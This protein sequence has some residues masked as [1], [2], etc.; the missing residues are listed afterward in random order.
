MTYPAY[1]K[2]KESG[3]PW[4]DIIPDCWGTTALKRYLSTPVTDGPHETPEF[5]DEGVP[6]IS[7]EAIKGSKIDFDKKRGYISKEYDAICAKKYKPKRG[8][9]Y[10]V[11]SGATTGNVAMV[12]TDDDFNIWSPLAAI[13]AN[14]DFMYDRFLFHFL[15]SEVFKTSI[16]QGWSFGT[17]QNIG[18]NIIENLQVVLPAFPEQKAIAEFL[19]KKT[20]EIDTLITKKDELLKLLVEQ[21]TALITHAVTK[22][23]NPSTPMKDSGIDWLG[24]VPEE[25]EVIKSRRFSFCEKGKATKPE[26]STENGLPLLAMDY[27]RGDG[28]PELVEPTPRDIITKDGDILLL[29][30]GSNAGEFLRS[31]TGV[32]SATIA[33]V[34]ISKDLD[35]NYIYYALK[36]SEE[37]LKMAN[38]GM[39]IPH[40]NGTALKELH[41]S[42]PPL[43]EQKAIAE[44]LDKKTAE[45]DVTMQKISE[46]IDRLKEYRTALITNAV[47][48]KIKVV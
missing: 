45:I 21:R 28:E 12:E 10:V 11:K 39:G 1:E 27:L 36:S 46:A 22:G 44:F 26:N 3:V 42:I 29:W 20:A 9:I 14:P 15:C 48:G 30:D 19:D 25:W 43:S 24:Q 40:V 7:A 17:Q 35:I 31:K 13:R 33:R 4:L 47:T 2:Y 8:D 16:E 34:Y 23:L 37:E 38:I 32:L 5:L 18:M 41:Y 6:F